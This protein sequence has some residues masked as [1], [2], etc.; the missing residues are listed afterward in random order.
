MLYTNLRE[1]RRTGRDTE[2]DHDRVSHQGHRL[3][4]A[5]LGTLP[6]IREEQSDMNLGFKGYRDRLLPLLQDASCLS[7][8]R[9]TANNIASHPVQEKSA[10]EQKEMTAWPCFFWQLRVVSIWA[11][12]GSC[13]QCLRMDSSG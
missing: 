6:H 4:K 12:M 1:M 2:F 3:Y 11:K 5:C 7:S 13:M 8:P 10:T 9:N